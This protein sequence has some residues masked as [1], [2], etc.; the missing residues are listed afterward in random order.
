MATL[1]FA[2]A[3]EMK[4]AV[5]EKGEVSVNTTTSSDSQTHDWLFMSLDQ[6]HK[7]ITLQRQEAR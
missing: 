4:I 3:G 7:H 2:T 1:S 5:V 6:P